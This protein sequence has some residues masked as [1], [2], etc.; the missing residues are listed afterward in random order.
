MAKIGMEYVVSAELTESNTGGEYS[1]T[2][3]NGRYW[4][5]SSSFTGSPTNADVKDYGDDRAV[6]TDTSMTGGSLSVE[7]NEDTLELESWL[8]GHTYDPSTKKMI[9]NSSDVPPFLGTG[10][11]GK[12]RRNNQTV[13][14]AVVYYKTQ[15]SNP[16]DGMQTK[17]E[18]TT[19]NHTSFSGSIFECEDHAWK[20]AQEFTTLEAA[21]SYLNTLFGIS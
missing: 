3:A 12:S 4:G 11:I 18:N 1:R 15:F 17:Q 6:E 19:F 14:R 9:C 13:Y 20:E 2:Y 10:A 16:E 7:L 8:L 5:P 21:K